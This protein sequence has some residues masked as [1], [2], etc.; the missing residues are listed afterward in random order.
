VNSKKAIL[1]GM[2]LVAAVLAGAPAASAATWPPTAPRVAIPTERVAGPDRYSTAV[3]IAQKTYP[4]WAG[5]SHVIVASGDDRAAADALSAASLCWAYDAPMLLVAKNRTPVQIRAALAAIVS[6]NTTVTVTVVGGPGSIPAARIAELKSIVG[7]K[8][9][10]EQPWKTGDRFSVARGISARSSLVASATARTVPDAVFIAGA[11]SA[12]TFWDVLAASAVTRNTG[13]PILL[14]ASRK[15]PAS[16]A[17]AL[18]TMPTAQRIIVGGTGTVSSAMFVKLGGDVRWGG[19]DRYATATTIAT[20]A[21]AAGWA[22]PTRI[23]VA[24]AMPDA[25]TGSGLIGRDGGV[26]LLSGR[27]RLNKTTWQLV[28]SP[29]TVPVSGYLLGG[30]GSASA[31]LLSELNGAP[32]M[33]AFG[34]TTPAAYGG[35]TT[36]V[37]GSVGGNTTSISLQLNGVTKNTVAVSPWGTFDFGTIAVPSAGLKISVVAGNPDGKTTTLTRQVT[38]LKFPYATCIVIDKSEFKLYWVKNNQLIKVYPIAIGRN[39]METPIA[40]WKILAKYKT[41]PS[42]VYGP[43]KMRMFRRV[44]NKYVFTAYAVHGTNQEWVIGTKASHGCIRMYN[45]DVLELWP[46]V[47]MGTMVVTQP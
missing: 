42:S 46:Q 33:P 1:I 14:T 25:V 28:S 10:V 47:P 41:D 20:R 36:R 4:A 11:E 21:A 2:A 16:T 6:A 12:K 44:G 29:T 27:E 5:V 34:S 22:D 9:S 43:R 38:R 3:A 17:A 7:P 13:I 37:A 30:T 39:G 31:A 40:T 19:V 26:L 23:A 45:R 18:A 8:G 15:V 32:A 35:A 24:V